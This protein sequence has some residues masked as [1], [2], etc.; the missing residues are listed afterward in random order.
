VKRTV[1][2]TGAIAPTIAIGP[3]DQ[4]RKTSRD[5]MARGA[6]INATAD[7]DTTVNQSVTSAGMNAKNEAAPS[8]NDRGKFD[9][10]FDEHLPL[11]VRGLMPQSAA[12][13]VL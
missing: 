5:L 9:A 1:P 10:L 12:L 4:I 13:G 8:V 6:D 3:G 2:Q 7:G 11:I